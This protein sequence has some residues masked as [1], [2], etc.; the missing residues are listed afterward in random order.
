MDDYGVY[1]DLT[2]AGLLLGNS[3]R[4]DAGRLLDKK[5]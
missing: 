5:R 4:A 1:R 2:G 3:K